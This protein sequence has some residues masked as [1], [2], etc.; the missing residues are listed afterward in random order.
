MQLS[1]W[2][3][4][5]SISAR[6]IEP[7]SR[8]ALEESLHST[9]SEDTAS[10]IVR[11]AGG[12]Y[13]DAALAET[14]LSS[15]HLDHFLAFDT[16]RGE[17]HCAAGV[18]L[19]A[20]LRLTMA[21][22]FFLPVVPGTRFVSVG[23]AIAA[24]VHGKNHHLDGC[25]SNF[26]QSFSLLLASGEVLP[27]SREQNSELFTATCGGMGLTGIILDARLILK[28][29]PGLFIRNQT[30]M[31]GNLEETLELLGDHSKRQYSVAWIDC[32]SRGKQLG[33]GCAFL[34]DHDDVPLQTDNYQ[35]HS[36]KLATVPLT[37]PGWLLNG[38]TM[39]SFNWLYYQRQ[40][41]R[42]VESQ[43]HY[44]N[45]FFPLD[46]IGH[47][48]RL[49][50]SKGFIQYQLVLPEDAAP[51]G[52]QTVL[53]KV[54]DAGKGSFLAVLKQFGAANNNPLS[55]PLSGY[56]LTLDFKMENSLLPLLE[57]LDAIV[58]DHGG[59]LYLAK[60]ARMSE[61]VFKAGYPRWQ[62]FMAVRERFDPEERFASLLSQRLGLSA[63]PTEH[64]NKGTAGR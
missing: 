18:S 54:S 60:D 10:L 24:D 26:V 49:Y 12:S 14:V 28:K 29:V 19:D 23:G 9:L 62:E 30:L 32:L 52:M 1:G 8:Q 40:K 25:F 16:E 46:R 64:A 7:A 59:R 42:A 31:T 51:A 36:G 45:Y 53:T 39:R 58:L 61:A 38:L 34:G 15:R 27:C 6:V 4:Y 41:L 55:F 35:H 11:G 2:G 21:K 33:R 22:G 48:N 20:I 47:W 13:G 57:E 17:I 56:T 50:G 5:P 3:R 44:Q 63:R 37:T 43:V